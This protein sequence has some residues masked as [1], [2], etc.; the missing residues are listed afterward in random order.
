MRFFDSRICA[1][2]FIVTLVSLVADVCS[3]SNQARTDG[4]VIK[5]TTRQKMPVVI[6]NDT[7]VITI[8]GGDSVRIIG[9]KRLTFEQK[10]LVETSDGNRGYLQPSQLP[11]EYLVVDGEYKGDTL[12]SMQPEYMGRSVHKYKAR[13]SAGNEIEVDGEDFAPILGGWEKY[14]LDGAFSVATQTGMEKCKGRTLADIEKKYGMARNV[15][16]L[17][18]GSS[19]ATFWVYAY[20]KDGRR[21]EPTITFD[22]EGGAS[23]FGYDFIKSKVKNAWML[24]IL[25]LSGMIIDMPLTRMLTKSDAYSTPTRSGRPVPWYVYVL[26]VFALMALLAWYLLTPSLI[27]LLMGWL[28]AYPAVF[29]PLSNKVL[30]I[31]IFTVAVVCSYFWIISLMAWGMHWILIIP[32]FFASRYCYRFATEY[33][34]NC[35]PHQRCP[36]CRHIHT[37]AFDHDEV[38]GSKYMKGAD[39]KKDKL[40]GSS[41]SRYQTWTQVTTT[42]S[43]GR[44]TSHREDIQNHKMRHDTYQYIDFEVTYL[45]TFYLN[46]FICSNCKYHETSESTTQKEV[47]RRMVGAHT[48]TESYEV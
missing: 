31:I 7:T 16:V 40:L 2:L 22:S 21:Y 10:I 29:K 23:D 34:D 19:K 37:I 33:L 12:V 48:D 1:I 24:R 42:W 14:N 30:R 26:F 43:D 36:E 32:V 5:L 13:T 39:I 25:P 46:H 17:P 6:G 28:V 41:D 44:K 11:L 3:T 9:F 45:V 27:V 8:A 47:D 20:G 15:L 35:V 18:D 38:T 4:P